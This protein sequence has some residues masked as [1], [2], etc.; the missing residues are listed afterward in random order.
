MSDPNLRARVR[1]GLLKVEQLHS[2][3]GTFTTAGVGG[4]TAANFT[5]R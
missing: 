1:Q 3:A 4:S 5:S 2:L